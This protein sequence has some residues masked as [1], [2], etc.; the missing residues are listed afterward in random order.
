VKTRWSS[1]IPKKIELGPRLREEI[2]DIGNRSIESRVRSMSTGRMVIELRIE[3][4][5]EDMN[6]K[7][8]R[9]F[10][11]ELMIRNGVRRIRRISN[12]IELS[13]MGSKS[14]G[15]VGADITVA[16]TEAA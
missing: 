1:I 16:R 8:S 3:N 12:R 11:K 9:E 5:Q 4:E 13:R 14:I 15:H 6:P 2:E 10:G 7:Y